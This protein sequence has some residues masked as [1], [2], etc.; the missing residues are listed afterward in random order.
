MTPEYTLAT[1]PKKWD[2]LPGHNYGVICY[3]VFNRSRRKAFVDR[4]EAFDSI[5]EEISISWGSAID[6]VGRM[7]DAGLFLGVVDTALLYVGRD[8]GHDIGPMKLRVYDSFGG[9]PHALAFEVWG[10]VDAIDA[11]SD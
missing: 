3:A 5:G 9:P 2:H 10:P 1:C 7:Q 11:G 6:S 4:V 8:D